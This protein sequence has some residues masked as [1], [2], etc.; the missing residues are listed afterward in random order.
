MKKKLPMKGDPVPE[1]LRAKP[2]CACSRPATRNINGLWA[3]ELC[4]HTGTEMLD[5]LNA[6]LKARRG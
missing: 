3:C 5:L 1:W 6:P 2:I 4:F